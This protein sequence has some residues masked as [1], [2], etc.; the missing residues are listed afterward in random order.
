MA[1]RAEQRWAAISR[2]YE[3][4]GLTM[5]EF[6][7]ANGL[8]RNTLAF[9]RCELKKRRVIA[10]ATREQ[11][12]VEV[13]VGRHASEICLPEPTVVVALEGVSAH[14]VDDTETDLTLLRKVLV[15]LC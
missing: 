2:R 14:V 4:S 9:W 11:T 13:S 12:F 3:D 7:E 1:Q 5:R 6:A 10:V 8:N 15:A